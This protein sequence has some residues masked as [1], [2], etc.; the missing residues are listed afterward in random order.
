LDLPDTELPVYPRG[1]RR[2]KD[3]Q[4]EKRIIRL[5]EWRKKIAVELEIDPGVLINNTLLEE[6]A[7]KY[8]RTEDDFATIDLLKNWQ[9]KVL[10]EEILQVLN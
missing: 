3:P 1:E 4:I 9:R 6:L 2:A 5:K 7:R 10:G 8:P